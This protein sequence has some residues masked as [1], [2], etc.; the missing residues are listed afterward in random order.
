MTG[1][2]L[3][4]AQGAAVGTGEFGGGDGVADELAL[5]GVPVEGFA[6]AV[7]DVHEVAGNG[8]AAADDFVGDGLL[9]AANAVEEVAEVIA[10][11]V[12]FDFGVGE[13]LI[14]AF[15]YWLSMLTLS[16]LSDFFA[17][18]LPLRMTSNLPRLTFTSPSLPLKWTP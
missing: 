16:P 1:T 15:K 11:L 14:S 7:A 4:N 17:K 13:Q 12:E 10:A 3:G 8:T 6:G 2:G 5:D 9:A 18:T